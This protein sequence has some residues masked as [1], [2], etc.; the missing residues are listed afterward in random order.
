VKEK[1]EA[2]KKYF[3][4]MLRRG[5]LKNS[6]EANSNSS[7]GAPASGALSPVEALFHKHMKKSLSA[8]QAYCKDLQ[9]KNEK[10]QD[11]VMKDY[12][13]RMAAVPAD[14][15]G[16]LKQ[17]CETKVLQL[18]TAFDAQMELVL[19]SY[20]KHMKEFAPSPSFLPITVSVSIP[21]KALLLPNITLANS[22]TV[23]QL[24]DL[25]KEAL[26]K[27]KM[28]LA[29]WA[30]SNIFVWKKGSGKGEEQVLDESRAIVLQ[31][32]DPGAVLEV[33]GEVQFVAEAPKQCFCTSFKAGDQMDYFACKECGFNWICKN[34]TD[35]CH[36]GHTITPYIKNH[37]PG[38]ACCYCV[39]YKKCTLAK[40]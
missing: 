22:D 2:S 33:K 13:S 37:V 16:P 27:Q 23:R 30:P 11:A 7:A 39:K 21:Q 15:A 10:Q 17:E 9:E 5:N 12:A 28:P 40:K 20:D 32:V 3:E 6:K 34:C 26:A 25:V 18:R 4:R 35:I 14:K 38:W 24:R 36:K 8:Y 1:E 19:D 29:G 31:R